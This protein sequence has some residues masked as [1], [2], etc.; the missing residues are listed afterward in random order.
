VFLPQPFATN[1]GAPYKNSIPDTGGVGPEATWNLGFPPIT[2]QEEVSGGLP[3]LG[4]DFNGILYALSTHIFAQQ[5]GQLYRFS[6]AV[7]T[8]IGGYPLG[9]ALESTD[10]TTVW[11]NILAAN[12][13]DPD[14]EGAGW[15]PM[16]NYG[17][18]TKTGLTGG[19][20]TLTRA[21]SRR[22]VIVLSG[23]LASNLQI[24]LPTTLQNW[25]IANL[26]TGAFATTVRTAAQPVGVSVP[27]GGYAA[28]V[29][30]YSDGTN[31]N[32]TVAPLGIPIDQAATP[33]TIAQRTNAGYLLATYFNQ[34]SALEAPTIGAVF[35]QNVA[36]DGFL[37][38]ISL[39]NF[40]TQIFASAA[41]TGLPTAPTQAIGSNDTKIATDEYADRA[42]LGGIGATWTNFTVGAG[43]DFGTPYVNTTGRPIEVIVSVQAAAG[44]VTY[45]PTVQGVAISATSII[46]TGAI[47]PTTFTVPAGATYQVDILV[48]SYSVAG[49]R[50]LI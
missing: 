26:T 45:Q 6:S 39:A 17:F 5:A 18:T 32:P 36:A 25:L 3:P 35:V 19:I 22:G 23:A 43:R 28:P 13:N 47:T 41:L 20:V 38:K 1:A 7:S 33:L 24:V 27:Q 44:G 15:V 9:T 10:G 21:E 48:G 31:I 40:L 16:F 29:G 34:S 37:R 2:M 46:S 14:A 49:W 4:Q 30:V 42:T 8:A 50:E 12:T 11:F